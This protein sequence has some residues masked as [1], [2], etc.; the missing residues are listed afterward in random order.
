MK[1]LQQSDGSFFGDKWGEIDSRFTYA[2]LNCCSLLQ[3]LDDIDIESA[4]NYLLKC[5][6]FDGGFGCT[7]GNES[8]AGQAFC[9]IAGLKISG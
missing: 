8:H 5:Q 7:P 4:G 9:C 6:N 2:A 1:S 3:C